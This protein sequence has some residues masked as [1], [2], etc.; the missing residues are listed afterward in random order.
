M[1]LAEFISPEDHRNIVHAHKLYPTLRMNMVNV[2]AYF[3][4]NRTETHAT[5]CCQVAKKYAG[6]QKGAVEMLTHMKR[7]VMMSFPFSK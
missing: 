7:R 5:R 3:V 4:F 6:I 2:T 1:S